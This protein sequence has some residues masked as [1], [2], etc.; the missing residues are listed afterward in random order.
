MAES[1]DNDSFNITDFKARMAFKL[2]KYGEPHSST[3]KYERSNFTG[4]SK[5]VGHTPYCEV[6]TYDY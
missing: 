6:T 3:I 5:E 1:F 4:A 2:V